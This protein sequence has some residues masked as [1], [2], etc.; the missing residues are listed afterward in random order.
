MPT[1]YTTYSVYYNIPYCSSQVQGVRPQ[2]AANRLH[3]S[4]FSNPGI[5]FVEFEVITAVAMSSSIFWDKR[6]VV[7]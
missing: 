5:I 2:L 4:D 1:K 7:R 3:V 6:H